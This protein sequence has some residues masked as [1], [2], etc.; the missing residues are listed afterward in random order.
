MPK[1]FAALAGNQ[2]AARLVRLQD[3][4]V[5][6]PRARCLRQGRL[7]LLVA[8][9][10]INYRLAVRRP[11]IRSEASGSFLCDAST[12]RWSDALLEALG[13]D[14]AKLPE[15]VGSASVIGKRQQG[16][17][18]SRP[19]CRSGTP[20]VAGSGDMM[21][22]LLGLGPHRQRPGQR[23]LGDLVDRRNGRGEP[24]NRPEGDEPAIGERQLDPFRY[25]GRGRGVVPVVRRPSRRHRFG[26]PGRARSKTF[27][28]LDGEAAGVEAGIR[29]APVLPVP[30]R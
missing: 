28:R 22:Q 8:K 6:T 29:G 14:R 2:A 12:G 5:A 24:C 23:C 10:F 1:S 4:L 26:G 13:V 21:C 7:R 15:I 19:G 27:D 16:G 30:A 11:Q 20:V 3:G 9:D 18:W 25:R 17:G